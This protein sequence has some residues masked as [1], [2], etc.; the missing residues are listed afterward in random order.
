MNELK[1]QKL[2][3]LQSQHLEQAG[4]TAQKLQEPCFVY[5]LQSI[6]ATLTSTCVFTLRKTNTVSS[7]VHTT[8]KEMA[9][10]HSDYQTTFSKKLVA[11]LHVF[12]GPVT[13]LF[14]MRSRW[15]ELFRNHLHVKRNILILA[16]QKKMQNFLCSLVQ[17]VSFSKYLEK[18]FLTRN[19]IGRLSNSM[20][21]NFSL[22]ILKYLIKW[23][24]VYGFLLC[25]VSL[26][27]IDWLN[28]YLI[29]N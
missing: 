16:S 26:L 12:S 20:W 5:R 21:C 4:R 3:C 22:T 6:S 29:I 14:F 8:M 24:R 27:F 17:C 11:G 15:R 25:C 19:W 18:M 13:F 9:S 1:P 10:F 7:C 28:Y 23:M 2:S